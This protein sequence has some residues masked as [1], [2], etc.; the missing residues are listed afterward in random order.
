LEQAYDIVISGRAAHYDGVIQLPLAPIEYRLCASPAYVQ[1][2]G[3]LEH[4]SDL[5]AH[6]CMIFKPAGNSW[7]FKSSKGMITVDVHPKLVADDNNTLLQAAIRGVGI[8]LLPAYILRH[9]VAEGQLVE[10]LPE[11]PAQDNWFKAYIPKR[12]KNLKRINAFCDWI[13]LEMKQ[14]NS[15]KLKVNCI[16]D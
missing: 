10:L 5:V 8:A 13:A 1:A 9:A 12:L 15:I 16:K 11:F 7:N 2:R 4:P 6:H 3:P 14:L